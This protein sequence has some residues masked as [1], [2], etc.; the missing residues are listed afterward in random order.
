MMAISG[1]AAG[2]T[3]QDTIAAL[4]LNMARRD[5]LSESEREALAGARG[6]IRAHPRGTTLSRA[7]VPLEASTLLL[8]GLLGRVF[9]MPDGTRQIVALHVAGDFVDLHSLLLKT[10]D[11]DIVALSDVKVALFP[12]PGLRELS[13]REPHLTRMLWL[14][15]VIDAATHRAWTRRLSAPAAVGL[16]HLLCEMQCRLAIVGRASADSFMLDL[17]QTDLGDMTGLTAV[18]VNRMLRQMREQGLA[19]LRGGKV[20]I[21]DLARLRAFADFDPTYLYLELLPR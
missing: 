14:L 7:H 13:E 5:T 18:H 8:D 1:S 15:T 19:T 2:E 16:A 20:S 17:T 9:H 21:P 6:E 4:I 11:H 3:V 12:H 10:L